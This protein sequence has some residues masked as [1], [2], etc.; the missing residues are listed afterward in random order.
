MNTKQMQSSPQMATPISTLPLKTAPQDQTDIDDPMI[1]N[2]LKEFE[3]EMSQQAQQNQSIS[4]A[5]P[6]HNVPQ[7]TNVI[8]NN[9]AASASASAPSLQYNS[10]KNKWIDVNMLQKAGI[11]A[12][13]VL[14][15][16][17][18]NIINTF[19]AKVPV[20]QKYVSGKE[21]LI[22]LGLLTGIFYVLIHLQVL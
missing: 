11:I 1:Q 3:D 10:D 5:Q 9:S 20:I 13:F 22:N 19:V 8:L 7:P 21:L 18:Y 12:V 15:L 2:V 4:Q 16:Q 14:I 17:N 6:P